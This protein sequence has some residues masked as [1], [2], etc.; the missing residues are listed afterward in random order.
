MLPIFSDFDTHFVTQINALP[1]MKFNFVIRKDLKRRDK[2]TP[3]YLHVTAYSVRKRLNL[4]VHVNPKYWDERKQNV[5]AVDQV[6]SAINILIEQTRQ[7]VESIILKHR[8]EGS[9]LTA[10]MLITELTEE[11]YRANFITYFTKKLKDDAELAKG[12][13]DRLKS[14]LKKLEAYSS[15]IGFNEITIEYIEKYRNH[16]FTIGNQK[17]TVNANIQAI[18]KYL[19]LAQKEG[20][21]MPLRIEDIK[22]GST[23]GNRQALNP[24]EVK[25][26]AHYY[27]K[28]PTTTTTSLVLGYF[29]FSCMTGLR[30]SD[31]LMLRREQ[32]KYKDFSFNQVKTKKDQTISLNKFAYRIIEHNE[33]LF[34]RKLAEQTINEELKNIAFD[35]KIT[36]KVSFHVA[37]H[38]FATTFLRAG[39]KV[40]NLQK[41]L[42]HSKIATTM[43]YVHIVS[44]E[45]NKEIFKLDSLF[46]DFSS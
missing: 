16:L 15:H 41:L 46:K 13:K 3:V 38:T 30:L 7:K 5:K 18:T 11:A 33:F 17:T 8:I 1:K 2:L 21:K 12:S 32:L 45:A 28:I 25:S 24:A 23:N 44:E 4:E 29:L 10:T 6:Y 39:G 42:G 34:D 35:T 43:I 40:E 26:L 19:R 37:R 31:V 27:F 14:V 22:I 36:K 9:H 20:L